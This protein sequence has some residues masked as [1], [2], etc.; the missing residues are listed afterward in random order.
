MSDRALRIATLAHGHPAISA[1]GAEVAALSLHGEFGMRPELATLHV[2]CVPAGAAWSGMPRSNEAFVPDADLDNFRLLR[3]DLSGHAALVARLRHFAPDIVH[4]HHV[5]GFGADALVAVRRALPDAAIVL[6]LH[7]YLSICHASGQMV[8]TSGALCE[9]ASPE[10]CAGCFP[11]I[12]AASFRL[13]EEALQAIYADVDAFIAPSQFLARRYVDWGLDAGRVAVIDNVTR[14]AGPLPAAPPRPRRNRFAFFGQLN[15]FK[16][17]DLL[18]EAAIGVPAADWRDAGLA[19]HGSGLERQPAPFRQRIAGLLAAAGD[20]VDFR[21]PY[22][23]A[24]VDHLMADADWIVVPSIW[25]EN[26]PVV[27]QEA[28]RNHRPVIAANMGGMAEKVRDGV[29]GLLFQPRDAASLGAALTAAQSPD[30]WSAVTARI[31]PPPAPAATADQ[32]L[33]L[34]RALRSRL[35]A[36]I[37]RP[38]RKTAPAV[39]EGALGA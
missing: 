39:A 4:F 8:R 31:T 30:L 7:E 28:F 23:N 24:D 10:A 18:L 12:S 29:D 3:R 19:I 38:K 22:P 2:S 27:I 26:A 17:V 32:H 20:R 11:D 33:A 21:G 34:Y 13:R 25:W 1:A 14:V 16:G 36:H 37:A 5:L 9:G 35:S 6:T 15:P